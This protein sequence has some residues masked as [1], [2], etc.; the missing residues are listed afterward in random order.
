MVTPGPSSSDQPTR[1]SRWFNRIGLLPRIVVAMVLGIGLGFVMPD[2]LA[3]VFVTF[4][5]LF[6]AFLGF[7]IP[8]IIVGMVT[9]AIAELGRGAGAYLA[10]T[11]A[12]AYA[13]TLLSGFLTLAVGWNLFPLVLSSGAARTLDNPEKHFLTPFFSI[14]MPPVF[15]VMTALLLAFVVGVGLTMVQG[16]T[17][18]R[19]ADELRSLITLLIERIL[20]PLLPIYIFGMFL[21][22]TKNGQIRV[23]IATFATV[24]LIV[25]VLHILLLL[26][27]FSVAGAIVRRNPLVL[28]RR[29]MPAYATALGT[30]SSAATIPV[31]LQCVRRNGVREEIGSFTV[32]LCATIH[33]AGSTMKIVAFSLAIIV[34]TGMDVSL[35]QY[36][37]FIFMLGIT[38]IAAPGVPGGAIVAAVGI[39]QSM[40]GFD[41]TAVALMIAT[42][43]AI[44]SFGTACNVTGDGAIAVVVDKLFGN[45]SMKKI[46][47]TV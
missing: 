18:R 42:Y 31:T 46:Q 29:M 30:S 35:W 13:S 45:R 38:M 41:E 1:T 21:S 7:S 20:V 12:I 17:L 37:G 22:L 5:S 14:E 19:G 43:I 4:N 9:P 26:G 6:S 40:L 25:F 32:P 2:L 36:I 27:Q 11:A 34:I 23:V 24:M 10:V 33:L 15:G 47:A 39:L 3:Q 16:D 28:L 44:D 8:L